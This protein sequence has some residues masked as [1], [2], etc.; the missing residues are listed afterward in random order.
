METKYDWYLSKDRVLAV[1]GASRNREK[2]GYK[3]YNFFKGYYSKVYPVNP[4]A[5]N[6]DGDPVY[7]NL[8]SLPEMPDFVDVVVPPK[9]TLTVLEEAYRVGIK[10]VWL[11]PGS[12]DGEVLRKCEELDLDCVHGLCL[13]ETIMRRVNGPRDFE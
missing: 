1:V 12:E 4:N 10:R 13:M 8:S 3:L 2:W 7:P 5:Y 6:I 9:V 11:Q